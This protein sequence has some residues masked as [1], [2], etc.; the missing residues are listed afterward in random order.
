MKGPLPMMSRRL[1]V[2]GFGLL[3]A[4]PVLAGCS[5]GGPVEV[6]YTPSDPVVPPPAA[7][8]SGPAVP[9]EVARQKDSDAQSNLSKIASLISNGVATGATVVF[10]PAG[11]GGTQGNIHYSGSVGKEMLD[12]NGAAVVGADEHGGITI[13]TMWCVQQQGGTKMFHMDPTLKHPVQGPCG[14]AE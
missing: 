11:P 4:V 1:L 7:T 12:M 2:S 13:D 9:A 5:R 3:L 8:S 10:M 6:P 14:S